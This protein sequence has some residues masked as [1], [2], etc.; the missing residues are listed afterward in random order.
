[1]WIIYFYTKTEI[2]EAN[3]AEITAKDWYDARM[4]YEEAS[5]TYI[6]VPV[7]LMAHRCAI[8]QLPIPTSA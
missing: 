3:R 6:N 4:E 8:T 7:G 1:L 5:K 2:T